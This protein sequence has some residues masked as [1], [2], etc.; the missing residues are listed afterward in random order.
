MPHASNTPASGRPSRAAAKLELKVQYLETSS[1]RPDPANARKHSQ[2]Q[3]VRLKAIIGEF[4]F[5][6]PVLID[7][8]RKVIAGHARL[9][10]ARMLGMKTVPCLQLDHLS[11]GQKT[12]LALADNKIGDMSE[13]D[14]EALAAQLSQLCA[15]DFNIELTGFETAE[16]A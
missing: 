4:G 10:V 12:A 3:L 1:L 5:T 16:S 9:E 7:E 11:A 15:I 2:R 14:P 6:N 13:F 8:D